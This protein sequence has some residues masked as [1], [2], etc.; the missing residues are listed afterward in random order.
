MKRKIVCILMS[1]ILAISS[2][3]IQTI[4]AEEIIS[5]DE[6]SELEF[7]DEIENEYSQIED[8]TETVDADNE[9]IPECIENQEVEVSQNDVKFSDGAS[10]NTEGLKESSENNTRVIQSEYNGFWYN[11]TDENEVTITGYDGDVENGLIIPD[12]IQDYPV[13]E[14][15]HSQEKILR[16]N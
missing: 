3:Q 7:S 11:I 12:I 10:E 13:T 8:Q 4:F 15:Q 16:E 9:T 6:E 14:I 5:T 1:S 2:V